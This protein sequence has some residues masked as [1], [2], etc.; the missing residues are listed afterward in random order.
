MEISHNQEQRRRHGNFSEQRVLKQTLKTHEK[1]YFVYQGR[2]RF[3]LI[4]WTVLLEGK[5]L[6]IVIN[7]GS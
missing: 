2:W 6:F 4:I 7:W 1:L 5:P 3:V